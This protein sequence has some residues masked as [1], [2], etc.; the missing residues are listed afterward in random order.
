MYFSQSFAFNFKGMKTIKKTSFFT[1]LIFS[2]FL[3]ANCKKDATN[4]QTVTPNTPGPVKDASVPNKFIWNSMHDYYLWTEQVPNLAATKYSN[5]DTLN[6]FLNKYTDPEKLFYDLLYQYQT[7]DKWSFIVSDITTINDWIS[8]TSKTAGYNFMLAR[9][10]STNNLF[11]FVRYVLKGSPADLAGIRRG[12]I[13]IKVN[14]QQLTI[15]NYQ[16][17][18]NIESTYSLSF[19]T[20]INNTITPSGRTV[21]LTPI[22][23]QEN[24]ILM[25][26]VLTVS[27]AKVGYLVYNGFNSDFDLQ[28]NDVFK[29][30][31][32]QGISNLIL[33][34]RYNGGGSVQTAIYLASMIYGTY[35]TK[36]FIKNQYNTA[37]QQYV[38]STFGASYL[39]DNFTDKISA[40]STTAETPITTLNLPKLYVIATD[41]SAS[42]S[43]LL[44]NGLKPY[45]TVVQVGTNTYGKYV[46]SAT[47]QDEDATGKVNPNDP[48]AL[49]PIIV[50][51]LNSLGVSD[52]VN[53]LA[54]D[55]T[56][57]EDIANLLPFGDPNETLLQAALNNIQGLP[58]KGLPLK[59]ATIGLK[60]VADSQSFKPYSKD[61]YIK[62]RFAAPSN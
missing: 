20:I 29:Y 25:D 6:A 1:I 32:D 10:G 33:D 44:I 18:I 31:K 42:A 60:K 22:T 38:V 61:M 50:K 12:D 47:I 35:T 54:P 5:N 13:F 28:L 43:E 17:L 39:N 14:D 36:D 59:S 19:A 27:G 37:L 23:L 62:R 2:I 11:G 45:L 24:P 56:A 41:N 9:I 48:W 52:F 55:I 16:S 3:M 7:I 49:Q 15:S 46:A 4:N 51:I 53:G 57:E 26:T 40:T 21:N 8:G 30:F 34:L 58:Q